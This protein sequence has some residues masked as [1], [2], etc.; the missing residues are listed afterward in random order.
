M[1]TIEFQGA[2][3]TVTGSMHILRINGKTILLDCGLFQGKRDEAFERNKSFPFDPAAIDCLI[4]SHAHID[5]AGNIP[6]LSKK[7]FTGPIYSTPA[8]RDLANLMLLDCAFIQQKDAEF[9][10]KKRKK[11]GESPVEP[12]YATADVLKSMGQ[13]QTVGYNRPIPVAEN[14]TLTFF[15]A[16]HILG[17]AI[18]LLDIRANG[19]TSRLC[20]TGDLGRPNRPILR[21]PEFTGDVDVLLCESTY[22]GRFHAKEEVAANRIAEVMQR[23]IDRNGKI[24]VP[25]FA[26]G[27]TQE[28][29]YDL[30]RLRDAGRLPDIPIYVDSPLAVN[31]TQ[32]FRMHPE[33]VDEEYRGEILSHHDPF[34]MSNL[35]YITESEESKRLNALRGPMMIISPSGMCEAG[36][37]QHHLANNIGNPK[38]TILITGY[39]A[40]HTL[41]R[42]IVE[43]E[44]TV[45]I[46]GEEY[47]LKAEVA[48]MNSLSAH[49]DREELLGYVG[50]FNR[51]RLQNILLV[52]G[53]PDQQEKFSGA[54]TGD[55]GFKNVRIPKRGQT[56]EI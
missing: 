38:N 31:V 26:V 36:R 40:E 11:K 13:F 34:G 56:V 6:S 55:L 32:V 21:D 16:G 10:N 3:Q 24:I 29:I 17:S 51:D 52:H 46:Y 8:T 30:H 20:F 42:R 53:D 37:I 4:L 23:T 2:A 45:R 33:C 44:P 25:A 5:H 39:S 47:A 43:R 19:S 27:R 15:D 14:V 18:V 41:G 54:L 50:K 28:L 35:K 49:A 48:V 1:Y 7:G 9:V 22:G 12:L